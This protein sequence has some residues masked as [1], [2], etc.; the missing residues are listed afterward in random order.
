MTWTEA[1][2]YCQRN[3][4]DLVT[5]NTVD[6]VWLSKRLVQI[7][8]KEAWIGLHRDPEKDA[9]WKWINVKSGEGVAGPDLSQSSDWADGSQSAHCAPLTTDCGSFDPKTEKWYS[10]V[11]SQELEPVCYDD[12]LVV[13][14][15]NKT[16]E[17]ALRHCKAMTTPCADSPESCVCTYKMLSLHNQRDY[18]YVRE[19]IYRATTDEVWIGLRYLGGEWRWMNGEEPDNQGMLPECPSQLNNCGTLS[20]H[21]TNN[22]STTD[23]SERRNFICHRRRLIGEEKRKFAEKFKTFL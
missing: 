3:H 6:R 4:I 8:V 23:C 12:N 22:W 11:C 13:V 15:K 10:K 20:K 7:D 18:D 19:R 1:R 17:Q 14:N 21:G 9:V 16:W 5:W 2:Q